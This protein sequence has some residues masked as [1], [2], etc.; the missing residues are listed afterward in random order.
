MAALNKPERLYLKIFTRQGILFDSEI[1]SLSS[2]NIEGKFDVLRQHAQFISIIKDKITIR[3]LDGK[4]QEI[5]V[6]NAVM[7]V[8][9]EVIQVF[10]G[11]KPE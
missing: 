2:T 7:R 8:K 4:V 5:S 11:I 1:A 10:L 6:D 3:M 9:G